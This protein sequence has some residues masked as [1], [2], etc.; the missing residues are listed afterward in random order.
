MKAGKEEIVGLVQA[1]E[2][3]L[4]R[5]QSAEMALWE[6]R[7]AHIIEILSSLDRLRVWRQLPYGVGQQIPHVALDWDEQA[8]GLT[9]R[10][11]TRKLLEGQPRI[12]VQ[13]VSPEVYRFAGFT[14]S[15]V[16]IHPHTLCEGEEII[17]AR[18]V[19]EELT[20]ACQCG[21]S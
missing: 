4:T 7:V 14:R 19:R 15:Q 10:E 21:C 12:G 5:D 1:I 17:V 20:R 2:L 18:R 13:L 16:R 3:Y 11:L 8:L 6:R 9:H